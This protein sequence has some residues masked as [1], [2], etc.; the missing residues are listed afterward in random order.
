MAHMNETERSSKSDAAGPALVRRTCD[1]RQVTPSVAIVEAIATVEGRDPVALSKEA[2][3]LLVEYLDPEALDALVTNAR[4]TVDSFTATIDG[5]TV[6]ID[7]DELL[8]TEIQHGSP[9]P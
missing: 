6:R 1:W 7:E 2:G 3:F 8:L 4:G 5:Y 9:R